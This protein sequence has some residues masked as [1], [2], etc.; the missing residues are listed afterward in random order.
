MSA[1]KDYF[2]FLVAR[3]VLKPQLRRFL[4]L[5]DEIYPEMKNELEP[6]EKLYERLKPY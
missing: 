3:N 6:E 2:E 5:F 1:R 4:D